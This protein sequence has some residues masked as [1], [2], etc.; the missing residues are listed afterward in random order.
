MV[1]G[2]EVKNLAETTTT[3]IISLRC[4]KIGFSGGTNGLHGVGEP[5]PDRIPVWQMT[6]L[7]T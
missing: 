5:V 6:C 4:E 2:R 7:C 1:N 3:S